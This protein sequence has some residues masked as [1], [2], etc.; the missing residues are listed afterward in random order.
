MKKTLSLLFF[1]AVICFSLNAQVRVGATA[2][3]SFKFADD[4]EHIKG[5]NSLGITAFVPVYKGIEL[6]SSLTTGAYYFDFTYDS[7][8]LTN[9]IFSIGPG[10]NYSFNEKFS[11]GGYLDFGY[12]LI[13]F[14]KKDT[15]GDSYDDSYGDDLHYFLISP[16][17]TFEYKPVKNLSLG[18]F[19]KYDFF[20]GEDS[21]TDFEKPVSVG[22]NILYCF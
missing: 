16:M 11:L 7:I 8:K 22:L 1:L 18:I 12:N 20:C 21:T 5:I 14:V 15:Y 6:N 19:T 10:Y 3:T 2:A 13:K 17:I 4:S 9:L